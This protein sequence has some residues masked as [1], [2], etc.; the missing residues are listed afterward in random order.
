MKLVYDGKC[1]EREILA[2]PAA[3]DLLPKFDCASNNL[4]FGEN[5]AVLNSLFK[6]HNF[7]GKID[8]VYIDPPFA[9]NRRF[10]WNTTRTSTISSSR[11]DKP[12]YADE[13]LGA[14][15]LEF[16]RERLILIRELMSQTASIYLHTD[17]KIG[18]YL[19][20]LMDEIFGTSNFR[21]DITRIKCNPKNFRRKNYGNIKDQIL[22][23]T[24][25]ADSVWN[26]PVDDFSDEDI[27]RLFKKTDQDGRRYTTI[28]LHAPGE[29]RNGK[30]GKSWRGI[31][32]PKGRHW[33]SAP[34]VLEELDEQGLVEW[35][36]NG[37]PRKKIFADEKKGKKKQDIWD[38]KDPQYPIYPTEKN[39]E[40]LKTL[41]AAS[42]NTGDLVLDC[43]CGSGTAMRAAEELNRRWIGIDRSTEA[44]KIACKNLSEIANFQYIECKDV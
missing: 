21:G 23:Y 18:H 6:Y 38:Y 15:F 43:F 8:L 30:T 1:S 32:P 41:I 9:T 31:K 37:V 4:I 33:R 26:D 12:A 17:Y 28:P 3:A 22:F 42:S 13:L 2:R 39:F 29:T 16:M 24:K 7:A 44:V 5:F 11:N 10:S 25:T 34:S 14:G 36:R 35:S 40:M 19:K 20:I 27:S